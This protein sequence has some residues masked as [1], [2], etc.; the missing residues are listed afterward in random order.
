MNQR[1]RIERTP[2]L[3]VAF[4]ILIST[5]VAT[6]VPPH[7]AVAAIAPALMAI[8]I[9]AA[10]LAGSWIKG[11]RLLPSA[12]AAAACIA[13]GIASWFVILRHP[14]R[15]GTILPIIGAGTAVAVLLR[16]SRGR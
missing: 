4:G 12:A 1:P 7:G 14:D 8:S 9:I 2:A 3:V 15:V 10:D 6:M 16:S 5:A 11:A 13:L